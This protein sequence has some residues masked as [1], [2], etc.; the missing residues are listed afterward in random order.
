[1]LSAPPTQR[2]YNAKGQLLLGSNASDGNPLYNADKFINKRQTDKFT[3][4]QGFLFN[5][6]RGL[7]LKLTANW[8]YSEGHY[9]SFSK[10]YLSRPGVWVTTRSSSASFDRELSQ[11]YNGV[12][13]Y[14]ANIADI[15]SVK[16]LVGSEFYDIYDKGFLHLDRGTHR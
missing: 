5:I 11:T 6:Y 12:L 15:H 13:T 9:E 2:E 4:S 14:D 7:D 1:M 16:L 3:I 10:D 8:L